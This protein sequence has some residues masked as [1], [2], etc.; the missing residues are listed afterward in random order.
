ML[1]YRIFVLFIVL[2]YSLLC[3][4]VYESNIVIMVLGSHMEDI[5]DDRLNTALNFA[6]SQPPD[7]KITWYLTGGIKNKLESIDQT[8]EADLMKSKIKNRK[9]WN[10]EL[11]TKAKNTAENLL[12]FK[13]WLKNKELN[14]VYI[15]TSRFHY[16]RANIM[17]KLILNDTKFDWL[18]GNLEYPNCKMDEIFHS[19]N[20]KSDV[21]KAIKSN[22]F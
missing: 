17:S 15:A 18:L 8:C 3:I 22:Y 21:R 11:D 13:S 16:I 9:N 7:T 10:F 1:K 6:K 4:A 14:K 12:F 5:L 20:I 2:I 19:R